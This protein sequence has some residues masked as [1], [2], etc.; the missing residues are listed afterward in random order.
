MGGLIQPQAGSTRPPGGALSYATRTLFSL[1][2]LALL[3]LINLPFF[4]SPTDA[5]APQASQGLVDFTGH[6]P[7]TR[8]AKL[9]GAWLL[10]WRSP[11]A[12]RPAGSIAP[13]AVPVPGVWAGQQTPDG[14]VL[15][16]QARAVY[17]LT[18]RGLPPGSYRLH[19]PTIFGANRITIDDRIVARRGEVGDDAGTT[20]YVW[21]ST[22]IPVE[23][24]GR[25]I[26]LSIEVASHLHR[27]N[28]I[29]S[30]PVIG[31]AEAM[32]TWGALRW[33]QEML[34]QVALT[35]L[36]AISLSIFM[37]RRSDQVSLFVA[38]ACFGFI[39]S[40][41]LLGY[42]NLL[43]ILFPGLELRPMLA[44]VDL[45]GT[46]S[47]ACALAY[48]H[49]LFPAESPRRIFRGLLVLIG[50]FW[51]LQ[52]YNYSFSTILLTS[53]MNAYG[54][55]VQAIVF[56]WIIVI[57]IRAALYRRDGAVPFLIGMGMF[58]AS[59]IMMSIVAFGMMP[60][61]QVSGVDYSA[62]GVIIM[63]FSHLVVLA[64]RWSQTI[65]ASETMTEELRQLLE[66]NSS[67]TSEI[68]LEA[69]LT[70]IIEVTTRILHADRSTLFLY[71]AKQG[72]LWSL[73]AEGIDRKEIRI[74]A[75]EGLAGAAFTSG[76]TIAVADAYADPRFNK[77]IDA[78]TGFV[79]TSVLT[80]P[81]VARD[82]RKLGVMQAL[83][84]E[85]RGGFTD[86]DIARMSAFAAQAAI[87]IDNATLF[88][89]VVA[90]R[91]YN[92]SILGSMA[93]GVITL[94]GEARI[95]KLNEAALRML[96]VSEADLAGR[97]VREVLRAGNPWLI[98]EIDAVARSGSIRSLLDVTLAIADGSIDANITIVPLRS[99]SG[100]VG[101]LILLEDISEG[102]RLAGTMRRF[103]PQEVVQEVMG[104]G[105]DLMFGS[106]I[107]ASILFADIRSFTTIAE[108]LSARETV[109]MLNEIFT[110][111]F[112]AVASTDGMIDKYM[113]DAI[114]AVY[115]APLPHGQDSVNAVSGA[116][117]MIRLTDR[118]NLL[119]ATRGQPAL[120]LGIGIA[121]GEVVAG[122]IG[123]PKRMDYT[124][125]GD[126]VNL[127]ARLQ[128]STKAYKV[129]AIVCA[130]TASKIGA[131]HRLRELDLIRVRGRTQPTGIFEIAETSAISDALIAAYAAG[132]AATSARDWAGAAAAFAN[133][134]AIA[135]GDHPSAMML[136][137][138]QGAA[139]APPP[140]DWD[141]V[142]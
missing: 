44:L 133:A 114:M 66:V 82:G 131:R 6:G 100:Q 107:P 102:K 20:R 117:G 125:I 92:E 3:C 31:T 71:D 104:R 59:V 118:L 19:V 72:D 40:T 134:L 22:D 29:E 123:S 84:R 95:A 90:S 21:R 43:L 115:G 88:S 28:G 76:E 63:L 121:S 105:D 53:Q 48:A 77:A 80:M 127:A 57:L 41:M 70:R 85:G 39:P 91:N 78:Q 126:T 9:E 139:V 32:Q 45:C 124:V 138:V 65:H 119:R 112:E 110:E 8:P 75:D 36:G 101:L 64:E 98:D 129:N 94:D 97:D 99:E 120:R 137:R 106:A 108:K 46:A 141:G 17:R 14:M 83:N 42:D 69:L 49:T 68:E 50:G 27:R 33:A 132:R 142:W 4:L 2:M 38:L 81:I 67:I 37:F 12:G 54:F 122:T 61:S 35:V 140:D 128:D 25:D 96:R 7:L 15:P 23:A 47:V 34:F 103:M 16:A 26:A 30:A 86:A 73:V 93:S 130:T 58:F 111:L 116:I 5:T 109:D 74:A 113:G 11:L 55:W 51:L 10:D 1:A 13:F 62:F 87:S 136:A 56:G 60:G 79:T 18:I 52:A 135:P 24:T 89:E